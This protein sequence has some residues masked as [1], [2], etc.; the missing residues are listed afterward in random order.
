MANLPNKQNQPLNTLEPIL[1]RMLSGRSGSTL[2]MQLLGTSD[3][4]AFDRV[5]PFEDR[6]LTYLA[7]WAMALKEQVPPTD[8]W[9]FGTRF[10]EPGGFVG[11]F[12]SL[13]ARYWD[14]DAMWRQALSSSWQQFSQVTFEKHIGDVCPKYYAEKCAPWL[15]TYLKDIIDYRII[16]L[17]RDPR[18]TFLS[19]KA[20][21]KKRGFPDFSRHKWEGDMAFAKRWVGLIRQRA[22]FAKK[23]LEMSNGML[24]RYEELVADLARQAQRLEDWLGVELNARQVESQIDNF[25]H[26]MTSKSPSLSVGRWRREMPPRLRDF[27]TKELRNELTHFDYEV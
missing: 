21:N 3:E 26:H 8:E 15:S 6:Y 19:I 4:I 13:E 23:E 16:L 25:A 27:I 12:P 17:V 20:F 5:Y 11:S 22:A 14:S 18:D 7:R 24:V 1:I 10:T 9:N 2:L